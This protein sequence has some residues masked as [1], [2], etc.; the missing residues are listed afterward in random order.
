[1]CSTTCSL[2][3]IVDMYIHMKLPDGAHAIVVSWPGKSEQVL[4]FVGALAPFKGL[5]TMERISF[6]QI[7]SYHKA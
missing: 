1:M 7:T 4:A 3:V 6:G 2:Q 5:T